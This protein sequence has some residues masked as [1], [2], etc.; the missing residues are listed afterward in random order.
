VAF[1]HLGRRAYPANT[2][3]FEEGERGEHAYIIETGSVE[4]VRRT[5]QGVH[6]VG[7]IPAGGIFGEMALIDGAPRIAGA[8]AIEDTVCTLVP[9]YVFEEK[10]KGTDPFVV[11]LLR[12]LLANARTATASAK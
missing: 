2:L 11:A 3:I 10:L 7:V 6:S 12:I 9:R 5:E 8:R 1:R 4:I